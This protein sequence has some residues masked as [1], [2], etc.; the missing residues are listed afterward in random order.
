MKTPNVIL[1]L[2]CIVV[3]QFSPCYSQGKDSLVT[4]PYPG[5]ITEPPVVLSESYHQLSYSK[6][7]NQQTF[8]TKDPIEKVMAHYTKV[9]GAFEEQ[10]PGSYFRE[11]IPSNDVMD[12][13]AKQG[14]QMGETR[15][16]AGITLFGK[17]VNYNVTVVNVMDKLKSAYLM[18]FNSLDVEDPSTVTKHLEDPELK[19]TIARYEHVK[20]EYFPLVKDKYMDKVIWEKYIVAP[21]EAAAKEEQELVKKMTE[22]TTQ[23]KYDEATKVGDRMTQLSSRHTD[24]KRNWD[25]AIKCLQELEKNAYA[26]KIVIDKHPSQWDLSTW[27]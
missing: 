21:E 17:P 14:I 24:A 26:T 3:L 1:F 13:L 11:A 8:Y 7:S 15:V 19:Q 12:F 2:V 4:A 16:F 6:Q 5:S 10:S 25:M 9:L 20:W 23:M 18:R 22:L 27:K